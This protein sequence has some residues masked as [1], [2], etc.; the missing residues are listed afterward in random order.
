MLN[1]EKI[2]KIKKVIESCTTF[3]HINNVLKWINNM[4][5]LGDYKKYNLMLKAYQK[6]EELNDIETYNFRKSQIGE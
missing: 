1:T 2:E 5:W 6:N 4:E 3:N